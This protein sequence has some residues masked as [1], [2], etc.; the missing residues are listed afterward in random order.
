MFTVR[1]LGISSPPGAAVAASALALTAMTSAAHAG[2]RPASLPSVVAGTSGTI[3]YVKAYNLFIARGDGSGAR[4]ITSNGT[5]DAATTPRPS[6]T[7]A[8]SPP[9]G[10]LIIRMTQAG[11]V[12]DTI[13]PPALKNT[14]GESMDGAVNDVAI[15]PTA[16]RS[17]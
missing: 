14:A 12:L 13:D 1:H 11:K 4:K 6:P 5:K 3:V 16:A 10:T 2:H 9:P 17:R 15:S 7:P 8:S